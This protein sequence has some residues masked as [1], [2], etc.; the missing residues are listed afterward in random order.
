MTR[1]TFR[2]LDS[3]SAD[4]KRLHQFFSADI[5]LLTVF[6]PGAQVLQDAVLDRVNPSV[7]R[8][9]G[10]ILPGILDNGRIADVG[11]LLDDVKLAKQVESVPG[12]LQAFQF[13]VVQ[14][15]DI[16]YVPQPVVDQAVIVSSRAA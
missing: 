12:V 9:V 15:V 1:A 3:H 10:A 5:K 14:P 13:V 4:R 16:L 8:E 11:D 6:R 2:S 7:H